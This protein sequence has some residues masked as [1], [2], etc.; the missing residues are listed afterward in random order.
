MLL[1]PKSPLSTG[2]PKGHPLPKT[3]TKRREEK[4][5]KKKEA[6]YPLIRGDGARTS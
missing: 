5:G 1:I 4:E 3:V 2:L 6:G